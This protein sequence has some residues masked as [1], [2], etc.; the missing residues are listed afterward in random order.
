MHGLCMKRLQWKRNGHDHGAA[1][2]WRCS[3][4]MPVYLHYNSGLHVSTNGR[5]FADL[6]KAC[7]DAGRCHLPSSR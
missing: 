5:A 2:A 4:Y 6:L 7:C 1:L 3:A